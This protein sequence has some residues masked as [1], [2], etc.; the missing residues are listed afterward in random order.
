MR[1]YRALLHLYPKSFRSE[2]GNELCSLFGQ[3][4][5]DTSGPAASLLLWIRTFLEILFNAFAVHWD[6][7]RQDLRYTART[8]SRSPG[9]AIVAVLVAALG[10]GA[11]TAVFTVTDH[12]LIRPL[13]FAA[14]DRLVALWETTPGYSRMELSPLNY[15]DWKA[16]SASFESIAAHRGLSVNLSGQGEPERLE[17]SAITAELLPLLGVRPAIG[18]IFTAEDDRDGAP[19]TLLLSYGLWQAAFGGDQGVLGRKVLLDGVPATIIGV[20][21]RNFHFPRRDAEIWTPMRFAPAGFQ[22]RNDNYLNVVARLKPAVTL[23]QAREEMRLITAQLSRE[24]P[25][26]NARHGAAVNLLRDEISRQSRLLLAALFGAALCVLLISCSN[27][28]NLLL[29]RALARQREIAVRSSLGAGR[30]RLVRQ[31]LTESSVLALLGGAVGVLAAYAALP[32]LARLVPQSMPVP[33]PSIDLRVL[34]SSLV[35]TVITGIGF[36]VIPALRGASSTSLQEGARTGAGVRT[37]RL[38][39]TLVI[40]EV[41]VSVVLLVSA[42]LLIR[43]LPGVQSASY[44][45][46]LPMTVRGGIWPVSVDGNTQLDRSENHTACLRYVTPS[47]FE[48]LGIPLRSGRDVS[49]SD[50]ASSTPVA[51]VSESF[52]KRYWPG[53]NP[54]GRHFNF[55]FQER[56]VIG[57]VGDVRVRGLEGPSEPQVYLSHMQVPDNT[58]TW[59]AP[60]DLVIRSSVDD[61]TLLPAVHAIIRNADPA[62][63][64]SEVRSMADLVA[65]DTGPRRLQL[66]VLGAFAISAFLLAGIGIHGLLSFA[67]SQRSREIGVRIALG[68]QSG[69][70][71]SL[72]LRQS[73][74]LAAA[75]VALGTGLGYSAGRAM[76]SL[77]AGVSPADATAF[78]ASIT[79]VLLMA[80]FGS[81]VP[82]LR[83][84]RVDPT[85]AIR[86]E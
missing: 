44:I 5:R 79:I 52:V 39:S 26:E 81:L 78:L 30:E 12:A 23:K 32:L 27:L 59:Y 7:L 25:K 60:K 8:L 53:Q 84:L 29:A 36:G 62:L 55:A 77:L 49:D 20:M 2:Y 56:T 70:I 17:G 28:A 6:L 65:E 80:L 21:P 18:R 69:D 61:A 10:I 51:V 16:R 86:A 58:I 48:T 45:S 68:A 37:Q 71:L 11:G 43:A 1:F 15:R 14:P 19:G 74:I 67:V 42:G 63:P 76:Q 57:V 47:F 9:F 75:G 41:A 46:F 66:R 35:F 22:D 31:L 24:Y 83:A 40:T 3:Q 64:I 54:L 38:R 33:E 72:V 13:P 34:L 82:A 4:W 50:T 85:T 73:L